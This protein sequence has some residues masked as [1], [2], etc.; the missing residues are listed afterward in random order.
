[1]FVFEVGW[2]GVLVLYF[3]GCEEEE[4]LVYDGGVDVEDVWGG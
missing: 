4:V 3:V 1:M 2:D